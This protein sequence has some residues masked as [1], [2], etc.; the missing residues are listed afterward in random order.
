MFN[1]RLFG[2]NNSKAA[3]QAAHSPSK[4]C[5]KD[6][7]CDGAE[8]LISSDKA[9]AENWSQSSHYDG[10]EETEVN[11]NNM[12]PNYDKIDVSLNPFAPEVLLFA[13][14]SE[15]PRGEAPPEDIAFVEI[16]S[17]E[18]LRKRVESKS[19]ELLLAQRSLRDKEFEIQCTQDEVQDSNLN[20]L[21]LKKDLKSLVDK[22]ERLQA[23]LEEITLEREGYQEVNE[24]LHE[25]VTRMQEQL[26]VVKEDS[27]QVATLQEENRLRCEALEE[28]RAKAEAQKRYFSSTI[29]EYKEIMMNQEQMIQDYKYQIDLLQA[30][31]SES[32]KDDDSSSLHK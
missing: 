20:I 27:R 18:S 9:A 7:V 25:Q 3:E 31:M 32:N 21:I 22:V 2:Q 30:Q 17:Y 5:S 12:M 29:E 19:R 23:E 15:F 28:V 14:A 16:E 8:D 26:E 4:M 6:A 10:E 1:I 24:A 11:N 13:K